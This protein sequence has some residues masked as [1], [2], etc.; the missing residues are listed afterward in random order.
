MASRI[1]DGT[2]EWAPAVGGNHPET[3]KRKRRPMVDQAPVG[4]PSRL[5]NTYVFSLSSYNEIKNNSGTVLSLL[6]VLTT[7]CN[8]RICWDDINCCFNLVRHSQKCW[9]GRLCC[10]RPCKSHAFDRNCVDSDTGG[11]AHQCTAV[12]ECVQRCV[13]K[14]LYICSLDVYCMYV[15]LCVCCCFFCVIWNN[16]KHEIMRPRSGHNTYSNFQHDQIYFVVVLSNLFFVVIV[17][18]VQRSTE[19][20][21]ILG[22]FSRTT[23]HSE[24]HNT[25]EPI[26][27]GILVGK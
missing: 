23:E 7:R 22:I 24:Q 10:R 14:H 13:G 26:I 18:H 20:P 25:D 27:L 4:A 15:S 16:G 5:T 11:C 1:R 8:A 12:G 3:N 9:L 21:A 2:T 6:S 19:E 17:Q